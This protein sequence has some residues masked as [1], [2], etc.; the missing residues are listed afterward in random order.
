[1]FYERLADALPLSSI[2]LLTKDFKYPLPSEIIIFYSWKNGTQ[3]ADNAD[4][5]TLWLA[6]LHIFLSLEDNITTYANISRSDLHASLIPDNLFPLFRSGAGE[7][8][9]IDIDT[10]SVTYGKLFA[11]TLSEPE[12]NVLSLF[13]DSLKSF[14]YSVIEC[15]ECGAYIPEGNRINCNE[16]DEVKIFYKHNPNSEYWKFYH[17]FLE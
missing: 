8:T 16:K 2:E 11:F 9:L 10:A 5:S 1:M 3:N 14:L 13:A 12:L 4:L 6:P 17:D 7:L 15:Y